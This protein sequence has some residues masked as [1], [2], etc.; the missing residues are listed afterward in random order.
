MHEMSIAQSILEVVQ[1][2]ARD[3]GHTGDVNV[4]RVRSVRLKVG[5]MAGVAPESLQFCFEVASEGTVAR[6]AELL[7]DDFWK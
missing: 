2:Y 3:N 6:G 5:E 7:I 1:Q 4:P